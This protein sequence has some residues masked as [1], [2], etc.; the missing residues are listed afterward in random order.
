MHE[1]GAR[2]EK[3]GRPERASAL[4]GEGGG[5]PGQRVSSFFMPSSSPSTVRGNMGNTPAMVS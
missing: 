1:K 2:R 5:R 4:Q 3:R